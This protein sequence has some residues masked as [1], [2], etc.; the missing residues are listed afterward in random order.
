MDTYGHPWSYITQ[1]SLDESF[2][3]LYHASSVL[4]G[5]TVPVGALILSDVVCER[6]R[7]SLVSGFIT[8]P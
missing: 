2:T 4:L 3:G 1:H 8:A 6:V 5:E 7:D